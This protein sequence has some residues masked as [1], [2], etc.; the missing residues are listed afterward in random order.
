VY[1]LKES[2]L[3]STTASISSFPRLSSPLLLCG[4]FSSLNPPRQP[5][6]QQQKPYIECH[7]RPQ[8]AKIPPSPTPPHS[9]S[10]QIIIASPISA[11]L[12]IFRRS[13]IIQC[14]R[15]ISQERSKEAAACCVGRWL[16]D[17]DF[18]GRTHYCYVM[19]DV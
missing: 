14:S 19:E 5:S 18:G 11:I 12:T 16:Q 6:K 15:T 13:R 9:Q 7:I 1:Q 4:P 8:N 2:R 10:L 17:I 3:I